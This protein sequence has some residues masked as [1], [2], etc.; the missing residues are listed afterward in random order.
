MIDIIIIEDEIHAREGLKKMIYLIN[1][2]V[3]IVAETGYVN[4][5]IAL[6]NRHKPQLIFLDILLEDGIGF[7]ILK[8]QNLLS[9]KIIFTTAYNQ[10]AIKAFKYSAVD[11]LL[12]PINPLDLENALNRALKSIKK[13]V[14]YNKLLDV[15]KNNFEGKEQKIVLKT[16]NNHHVFFI[17]EIIRLEADSAYT[18]FMTLRGRLIVSKNL[19]YYQDLL[20]DV[21]IRCHQ[22]HLVN[23]AHIV[24]VQK[25]T[26]VLSNEET[27]PISTRKKTEVLENLNR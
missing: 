7:D 19:K 11:Y 26:V 24:K 14:N 4:E 9:F 8:Q 12:K 1:P 3:N 25:N 23:K 13:D 20:G 2:T 16:Q 15:L 21:F 17:K 27:I 22:S 5:A 6:I 18:S 10:Y